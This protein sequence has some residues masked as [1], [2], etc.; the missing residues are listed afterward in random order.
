MQIANT[1]A[2]NRLENSRSQRII[3]LLE[4]VSLVHAYGRRGGNTE[5]RSMELISFSRPARARV[6]GERVQA[7][8]QDHARPSRA[9]SGPPPG[10]GERFSKSQPNSLAHRSL[11]S[12]VVTIEEAGETIT[13][14]ESGAIV[15]YLVETYG[16]G[17]L[18]V[19]A[20]NKALRARY[21]YWLH[22]AEVCTALLRRCGPC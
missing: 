1:P 19:A 12:P 13:L 14:A 10:K 2:T 5:T 18:S 4:E 11:Q 3:W 20:T 9:Q 22:F 16:N 17:K 15:E 21:L 8:H 6:H 7:K